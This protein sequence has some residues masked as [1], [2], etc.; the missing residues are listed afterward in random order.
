MKL[1]ILFLLA[2][3]VNA[4]S[5]D[6]LMLRPR[7]DGVTDYDPG[8]I[9]FYD[10]RW[11]AA[12]LSVQYTGLQAR[13]HESLER[14]TLTLPPA[15]ATEDSCIIVDPDGQMSYAPLDAAGACRRGRYR[16]PGRYIGLNSWATGIGATWFYRLAGGALAGSIDP[17]WVDSYAIQEN[18][19]FGAWI[20]PVPGGLSDPP[21]FWA[22]VIPGNAIGTNSLDYYVGCV[23]PSTLL[24]AD[25]PQ[26]ILSFDLLGSPAAPFDEPHTSVFA[27]GAAGRLH[28]IEVELT[29][30]A[31][32]HVGD[33]CIVAIKRTVGPG[34]FNTTHFLEVGLE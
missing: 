21:V 34:D 14:Y 30:N 27:A 32:W 26:G 11:P 33:L 16:L 5:F 12:A 22:Y 24:E 13:D 19:N 28:R 8:A 6:R 23:T 3:A 2:V 31:D 29:N 15:A 10:A 18:P 7:A 4:Q 1:P 17:Y 9:R 25:D 20:F